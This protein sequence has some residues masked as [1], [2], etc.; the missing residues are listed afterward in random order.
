MPLINQT[1]GSYYQKE[2]NSGSYQF[3]S[4]DTIVN[5]FIVAYVGEGKIIPKVRKADVGF[6]AQRAFQELSF[7]T[8]KSIKS[9][10]MIV[11]PSLRLMLPQ[12]YVN[13][14]NISWSDS[15]GIQHTI[16]PTS[17]TSNPFPLQQDVNGDLVFDENE[18]LV[19]SSNLISNGGFNNNGADWT[20]DTAA[21]N[22]GDTSVLLPVPQTYNNTAQGNTA[23]GIIEINAPE[24]IEG[25]TYV[26]TYDIVVPSSAGGTLDLANH[27]TQASTLNSTTANGDVSLASVTVNAN[28][29]IT[30]L[31]GPNNTGKL[32]L[33]KNAIFDGIIDNINVKVSGSIETSRTS[34]KYKSL[35]PSPNQ[36]VNFE[37][38]TYW[39]MHDQRYGLEPQYAQSNGSFFIDKEVL[40]LSS[41]LSGKT[42][43]IKYLSDNLGTYA[44]LQ[45]H[46]FAEEATYKHIAYAILSTRANVPH[47]Q[48]ARFKKE[49]F[50]E[51]R[52]AKLRLS[53]I[54]L[55]EITQVLRGKS[56][57]IKH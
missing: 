15:S 6:H 23:A 2:T 21:W 19:T 36:S 10:E 55:E 39:K 53:N 26:I 11:P 16:Y 35:T 13:Y 25:R 18:A 49:R 57:Q 34:S 24:I 37:D 43:T 38:E 30:W 50:A 45:I 44:E 51:V 47:F 32:V 5:Q 27:T 40:H 9:H 46:K 29:S 54:K 41:N 48:V 7:D 12:D 4:L 31:Q 56:K 22:V 14:T 8:F 17:K 42:L 20:I 33:F 3:V 52:K 28:H 1:Q